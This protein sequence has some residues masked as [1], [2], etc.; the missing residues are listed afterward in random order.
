ML[1][2]GVAE[3]TVALLVVTSRE[4]CDATMST[5]AMTLSVKLEMDKVL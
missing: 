2:S 3:A 1:S 5:L 4:V